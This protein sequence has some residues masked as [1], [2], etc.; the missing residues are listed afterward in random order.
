MKIKYI[1]VEL[2]IATVVQRLQVDPVAEPHIPQIR[3]A[4][5]DCPDIAEPLP[6]FAPSL[7]RQL[8]SVLC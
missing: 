3:K 7:P 8:V 1:S 4:A 5:I 6:G 2:P